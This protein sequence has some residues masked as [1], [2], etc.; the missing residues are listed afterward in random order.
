MMEGTLAPGESPI[1]LE[2]AQ[3]DRHGYLFGRKITASLSPLLHKTIYEQIGLNWAQVRFDS[4][5]MKTFLKLIQH[6]QFYGV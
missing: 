6:P 2:V 1:A 3:L 4:A 5:D